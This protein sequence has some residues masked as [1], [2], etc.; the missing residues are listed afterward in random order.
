MK[1]KNLLAIFVAVFALVFT[2][3]M[4]SNSAQAAYGRGSKVTV[5]KSYRG[6]WYSYDDGVTPKKVKFTTHTWNGKTI[7]HQSSKFDGMSQAMSATTKKQKK[8]VKKMEK[9]VKNWR[10][11]RYTKFHKKTY[12]EVNP[13]LTFETWYLYRPVTVKI[14]GY[15]QHILAFTS[16]YSGGNLYKSKSLARKMKN[17]KFSGVRYY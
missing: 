5:P 7:Y 13:W 17:H 9:A 12:L 16:R 6:T 10:S 3:G 11:G 1:K 8:A 2:L 14:N 15:K 4:Q